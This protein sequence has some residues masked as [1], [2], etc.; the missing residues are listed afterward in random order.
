MFDRID[1]FTFEEKNA[2]PIQH[3][4]F[5]MLENHSFDQMLGCFEQ[6]YPELDGVTLQTHRFNLDEKNHPVYQTV[7]TEKQ[8][9]LDP[10]HDT[11]NVLYQINNDNSGFLK[12]FIANYPHSSDEDRANVMGYYPMGFLPALHALADQFTICDHWFASI[13]GPTWPNRFFALSGT[14]SGRVTMPDSIT[15]LNFI[16]DLFY[17]YQDTIFDRLDEASK[18]WRIY[19][20]DFAISLALTHQR[21]F[22]NLMN[23]HK[24]DRFFEDCR[25]TA[26]KFPE[27]VFIEPKYLGVDQND[28]HPP[29]NTMKAQKLIADVYNAIRSNPVLWESTLLV[30]TYDEH[31]GF[32]DHVSPPAAVPPDHHTE[33]YTFDRLG[34]RVPAL[35]I[36]PWVKKGVIKT[37]FDHTSLLKYLID[38]WNLRPLGERTRHANSIA[39]ALD[40][41][42]EPMLDCLPF[43]RVSNASLISE[44]VEK[45]IWNYTTDNKKT[46]HLFANYLEN[47]LPK[48]HIHGEVSTYAWGKEQLGHALISWGM[49]LTKDSYE[50]HQAR[51]AHTC[52]VVSNTIENK[53]KNSIY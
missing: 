21:N 42:Q 39:V 26:E 36:S 10:F 29:H 9:L 25:G 49:W 11:P 37:V 41:N 8:M 27:F 51:I 44:D 22:K 45:E 38:K 43:I 48:Q 53:P 31:G 3:V 33:E 19:Y 24:I 28:D 16:P 1:D 12:D 18:S 52:E 30:V 13:P 46:I 35:L 34:V 17:Q 14:S 50:Q 40:F 7:V 15:D 47:K 20:Y 5:L 6:K 4:V 32:Y 2:D 23:Y